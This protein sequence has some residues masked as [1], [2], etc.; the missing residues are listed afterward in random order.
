MAS[1]RRRTQWSRRRKSWPK[2]GCQGRRSRSR[3][4]RAADRLKSLGAV[5][6]R[7]WLRRLR[8][9]PAL[10]SPAKP[11]AIIAQVEASGTGKMA[12]VTL[13]KLLL[14]SANWAP[15]QQRS[16]LVSSETEI[17]LVF[18]KCGR[19]RPH[20]AGIIVLKPGPPELPTGR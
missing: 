2:S 8:R 4:D 13:E 1:F 3:R 19:R 10:P 11:N 16:G 5:A 14:Y 12:A 18:V 6:A 17:V 20:Q 7:D 9:R 15:A